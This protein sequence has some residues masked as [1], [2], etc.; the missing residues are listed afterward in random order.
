[1]SL[2]DQCE[3]YEFKQDYF[4]IR[5]LFETEFPDECDYYDL[6]NDQFE[7]VKKYWKTLDVASWWTFT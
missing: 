2:Y 1:M 5:D 7:E 4:K 3:Q 6:T